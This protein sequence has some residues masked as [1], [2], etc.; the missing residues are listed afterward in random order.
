MSLKC[1]TSAT[2]QVNWE[3][4]I[5]TPSLL[6]CGY[7]PTTCKK[8]EGYAQCVSSSRMSLENAIL[9][10]WGNDSGVSK[11]CKQYFLDNQVCYT[12]RLK[13]FE[14]GV[15]IRFHFGIVRIFDCG[16]A[17]IT[18]TLSTVK[19]D[20][21]NIKIKEYV[22]LVHDYIKSVYRKHND[23]YKTYIGKVSWQII[24]LN[25]LG[26]YETYDK[27]CLETIKR[28]A[29]QNGHHAI[30]EPEL[31]RGYMQIYVK[32]SSEKENTVNV[33]HTGKYMILGVKRLQYVHEIQECLLNI[34]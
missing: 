8:Y 20:K 23:A 14:N 13:G 5:H 3:G 27:L 28:R 9:G 34:Q 18:A 22:R 17:I 1:V 16:K 31:H 19:F 33:Y 21:I 6:V 25:A 15:S 29:I 4:K 12:K 7:L 26:K 11:V 10:F 30:F 32:D 2:I 24:S